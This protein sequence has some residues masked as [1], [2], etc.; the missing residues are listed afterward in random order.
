M[1]VISL[2]KTIVLASCAKAAEQW[3]WCFSNTKYSTMRQGSL[4]SRSSRPQS[5][6]RFRPYHRTEVVH[7]HHWCPTH[8]VLFEIWKKWFQQQFYQRRFGQKVFSERLSNCLTRKKMGNCHFAI[9]ALKCCFRTGSTHQWPNAPSKTHIWNPPS[10]R[11]M[12]KFDE[13]TIS[14]AFSQVGWSNETIG[15]VC[16]SLEISAMKFNV[17]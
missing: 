16:N 10:R 3:S 15:V 13:W 9:N 8:W 1:L 12:L 17:E 4:D 6:P 7:L 5:R 11:T 2:F 14:V